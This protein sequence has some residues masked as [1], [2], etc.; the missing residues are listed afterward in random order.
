MAQPP[1]EFA[2]TKRPLPNPPLD[3]RGRKRLRSPDE[4][5][6][7]HYCLPQRACDRIPLGR[8]ARQTPH[9]SVIG[10]NREDRKWR[11]WDRCGFAVSD[12]SSYLVAGNKALA[13]QRERELAGTFRADQLGRSQRAWLLVLSVLSHVERIR[14]LFRIPANR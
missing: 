12:G 5:F 1:R 2:A 3:R 6:G 13:S 8:T 14:G 9:E 11:R 10:T 7:E 4:Y